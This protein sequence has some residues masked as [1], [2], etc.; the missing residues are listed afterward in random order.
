[1]IAISSRIH[2]PLPLVLFTF[3]PFGIMM[4]FSFIGLFSL[5]VIAACIHAVV[6]VCFPTW[7][8][9]AG[10]VIVRCGVGCIGQTV[11]SFAACGASLG[12]F[13]VC[14]CCVAHLGKIYSTILV[15]TRETG[16]LSTIVNNFTPNIDVFREN[17]GF[18]QN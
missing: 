7:I 12:F 2:A 13:V 17:G 18:L 4:C 11:I 6:V 8:A 16:D 1:M 3:N 5:W 10:V 9:Q 15:L 14:V